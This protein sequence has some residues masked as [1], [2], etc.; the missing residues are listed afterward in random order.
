MKFVF[1]LQNGTKVAALPEG[2]DKF[3]IA[4]DLETSSELS[5]YYYLG[6]DIQYSLDALCVNLYDAFQD[7]IFPSRDEFYANYGIQP[8]WISRAGLDS[9]FDMSKDDTARCFSTSI[10]TRMAELGVKDD[11]LLEIYQEIEAKKFRYELQEWAAKRGKTPTLNLLYVVFL[12]VAYEN[13]LRFFYGNNETQL[14][15]AL[16]QMEHKYTRTQAKGKD[17]DYETLA[18]TIFKSIPDQYYEHLLRQLCSN[19]RSLTDAGLCWIEP[20]D[21][22][23]SF[24]EIEEAMEDADITMS[25]EEF[26]VLFAAW[27]AEIMTSQYAVGS[28]IDDEVR[29]NITRIQRLGVEDETKL[30]TRIKNHLDERGLSIPQHK[31]DGNGTWY[32]GL[33]CDCTPR[34]HPGRWWSARSFDHTDCHNHR[35]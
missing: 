14:L 23:D 2:Y 25:L 32:A 9:D 17:L 22:A 28:E 34:R 5:R 18:K 30:P 1:Y 31:C 16:N 15:E 10:P 26:K 33:S 21:I 35:R 12:K 8:Q 7:A 20:C 11:K 19:F 3:Y 6:D 4:E 27:A 29:R 13:K 24:D